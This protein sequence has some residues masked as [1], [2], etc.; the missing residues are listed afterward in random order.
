MK[1]N[2]C[3]NCGAPMHSFKCEYC[4]TRHVPTGG[5]CPDIFQATRPQHIVTE[6]YADNLVADTITC[7][8]AAFP[9][10]APYVGFARIANLNVEEIKI[11]HTGDIAIT[12]REGE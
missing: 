4:G 9:I 10:A 5:E 11:A 7:D 2:R 12:N 1:A 8:K 6:L 3:Q